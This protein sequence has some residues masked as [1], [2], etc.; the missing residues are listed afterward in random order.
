MDRLQFGNFINICDQNDPIRSAQKKNEF[1]VKLIV[2]LQAKRNRT[3]PEIEVGNS[4]K[5][6]RKKALAKKNALLIG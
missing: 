3:Y 5:I 6:M 4:V 1:E 2:S